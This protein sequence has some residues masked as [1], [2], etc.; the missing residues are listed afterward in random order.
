MSDV[1]PGLRDNQKKRLES[2]FDK[3]DALFSHE[4]TAVFGSDASRL[5]SLPA[6]VVRPRDES[7]LRELFQFAHEEAIPLYPR[8]RATNVVGLCIPD[9]KGIVISTAHLNAILEISDDDFI[10]RCQPGVV[11]ADL[12]AALAKH[13]R[14]Y[15]PD[16]ASKNFC[17]IGGNVAT[18]AGGMSAVKYGATR[19]H[20]L[21][22]RAV[23]PGGE[24]IVTGSR[25]H[26]NVVGYDLTKLFVG[27]E[28][29][30][31]FFTEITVK[32]LPL[33]EATASVLAGF[34]G[35]EEALIAAQALFAAGV[36]PTAMEFMAEDVLD[37]LKRV[38]PMPWS[39]E[40]RALLLLK[41]DG[42]TDILPAIALRLADILRRSSAVFVERADTPAEEEKLW[43]VRRLINQASYNIAP[44][45]IS[46][47]VTVPR[48]K[49]PKAVGRIKAIAREKRLPI[50][51]FGHLGDGNLHV[52]IMHH[53]TNPDERKRAL[54]AKEL[55]LTA[56]IELQGVL[57]GEH[58]V[59]LTKLPYLSLQLGATERKLMRRIKAAFDPK[60]ILNPGKGI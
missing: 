2:L 32:L 54:E 34:L 25:T 36:L 31:G 14:F 46:D 52:N 1:C 17:S 7:Q 47:D 55:V 15:A 29:T 27:S 35:L 59:G 56:V 5:F 11:T 51:V 45:K 40:V 21:G 60:G 49:V 10:A 22:L 38:G 4:E 20:I 58:G 24:V 6:A 41:V 33:P 39:D 13:K 30:L 9:P 18:G 42:F 53:A 12:Q 8:G 50:L 48:G 57:S 44:D 16:P 37:A 28:G 19:D 43:E 26:K 23:I 3:N